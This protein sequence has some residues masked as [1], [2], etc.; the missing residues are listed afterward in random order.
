MFKSVGIVDQK[1]IDEDFKTHFFIFMSLFYFFQ[2]SKKKK[3]IQ[4]IILIFATSIVLG[5]L[6]TS[7][8]SL[9]SCIL[10]FCQSTV[11]ADFLSTDHFVL[12][13]RGFG[14]PVGSE[15]AP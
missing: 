11:T 8:T 7:S 10:I 15:Y 12:L 4:N 14:Q 2:T 6:P 9:F 1:S 3:E 13:H 5:I